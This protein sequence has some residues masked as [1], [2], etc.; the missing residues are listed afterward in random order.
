MNL[1]R[2]ALSGGSLVGVEYVMKTEKG[3]IS[4]HSGGKF[5]A[6]GISSLSVNAAKSVVLPIIPQL[7]QLGDKVVTPLLVGG[8]YSLVTYFIKG[9]D[10]KHLLTRF[11]VSAGSEVVASWVEPAIRSTLGWTATPMSYNS[12]AQ[13]N[14]VGSTVKTN[15][16]LGSLAASSYPTSHSTLNW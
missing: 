12:L 16:V 15:A 14:G 13:V 8:V 3:I 11:L 6:Q 7:A 2:A 9:V 4:M 1:L 5:L 10:N